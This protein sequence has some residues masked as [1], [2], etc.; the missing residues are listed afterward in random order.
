M[1]TSKYLN[2][3][4]VVELNCTAKVI[5]MSR[6]VLFPF[7]AFWFCIRSFL[8]FSHTKRTKIRRGKRRWFCCA[9]YKRSHRENVTTSNLT[10]RFKTSRYLFIYFF[11]IF[12]ELCEFAGIC[13]HERVAVLLIEVWWC[14][15]TMTNLWMYT[16][17]GYTGCPKRSGTPMGIR[18]KGWENA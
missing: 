2:I 18:Y 6:A 12:H 16:L 3:N 10:P 9:W 14:P 5:Q 7:Q 8:S 1:T 17:N 4:N 15:I 13:N 11:N